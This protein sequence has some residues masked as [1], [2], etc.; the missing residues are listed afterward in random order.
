MEG[1]ATGF[2]LVS[3]VSSTGIVVEIRTFGRQAAQPSR[4]MRRGR[5]TGSP[6]ARA[7][8]GLSSSQAV[9]SPGQRSCWRRRVS[10]LPGCGASVSVQ[11]ARMP[12]SRPEPSHGPKRQL[13]PG[14]PPALPRRT[15]CTG[16]PSS[17]GGS[18]DWPSRARSGPAKPARR[19]GAHQ[20]R[21]STAASGPAGKLLAHDRGRRRRLG[22]ARWGRRGRSC[23]GRCRGVSRRCWRQRGCSRSAG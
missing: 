11:G 17:R 4:R 21:L 19:F 16:N 15:G 9:S 13:H 23:T 18:G 3:L 7:A 20:P 5:A 6:H 1:V 10:S 14:S 12:G 8:W 22:P 2:G